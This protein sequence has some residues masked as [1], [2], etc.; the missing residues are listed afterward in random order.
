MTAQQIIRMLDLISKMVRDD[1]TKV[2]G[3][4]LCQAY[5]AKYDESIDWHEFS[6]RLSQLATLGF[7]KHAG[8]DSSGQ[9]LYTLLTS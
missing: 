4:N 5:Y 2:S 9:C 8:H 6:K 3:M 7:I 1:F